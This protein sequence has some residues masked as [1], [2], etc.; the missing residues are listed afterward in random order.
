MGPNRGAGS[1]RYDVTDVPADPAS[2]RHV[3]LLE[4]RLQSNDQGAFR[5][6]RTPL[7]VV[8]ASLLCMRGCDE[9][10]AALP[11]PPPPPDCGGGH[12][13]VGARTLP[14]HG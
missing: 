13:S 6:T 7:C 11:P 14:T 9:P 3:A 4:K 10:S 1:P 5:S 8:W 2:E 12:G